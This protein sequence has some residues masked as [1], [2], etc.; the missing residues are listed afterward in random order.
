[1]I[2]A[3]SWYHEND[4]SWYILYS[5]GGHLQYMLWYVVLWYQQQ[6]KFWYCRTTL[7]QY[8]KLV[9]QVPSWNCKWSFYLIKQN[10]NWKLR[11]TKC[12]LPVPWYCRLHKIFGTV[13]TSVVFFSFYFPMLDK[14]IQGDS[15]GPMYQLDQKEKR[16][17]LLGLVNRGRGCARWFS[18]MTLRIT[19]HSINYHAWRHFQHFIV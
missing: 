13:P 9:L 17:V 2:A 15:G 5:R 3:I 7:K 1:M 6:M 18:F 16:G 4:F 10:R 14:C 11:S 8:H 12:N 19:K